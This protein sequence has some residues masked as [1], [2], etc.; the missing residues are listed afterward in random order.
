MLRDAE[1]VRRYVV[2]EHSFEDER[3]EK[4]RRFYG[5]M[6]MLQH[7]TKVDKLHW[8]FAWTALPSSLHDQTLRREAGR[9]PGRPA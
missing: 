1:H 7:G 5:L 4:L 2:V 8:S 9:Q 6:L 3:R